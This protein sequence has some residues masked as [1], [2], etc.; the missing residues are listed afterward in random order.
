VF[1]L[2]NLA[3]NLLSG[4]RRVGRHLLA[5]YCL[6]WSLAGAGFLA[7][8][9]A[10]SLTVAALATAWMGIFT[11]LANVSMDAHIAA[12]VPADRLARVYALQRVAVVGASAM[13]AFAVAAGIEASSGT[14]V[15]AA[16]AWMLLAG[17]LAAL[18]V[19]WSADA[20]GRA[21]RRGSGPSRP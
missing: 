17:T 7:L 12:V 4:A 10:P 11:P 2:G 1:G 13:G 15:G 6:S 8:A 3:G 21:T 16:G 20:A 14:V 5:W 19:G 18:G 9:L